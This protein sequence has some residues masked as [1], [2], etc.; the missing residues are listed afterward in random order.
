MLFFFT[1]MNR[2]IR[3]DLNFLQSSQRGMLFVM[4][5]EGTANQCCQGGSTTSG[6]FWKYSRGKNY[7]AMGRVFLGYFYNV[8][9]PPK[10]Y[11]DK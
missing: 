5:D 6:L 4:C 2:I 10:V 8:P 3:F 9:Q 7:R 1:Q 11:V